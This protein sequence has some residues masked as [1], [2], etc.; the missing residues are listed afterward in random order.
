MNY[1]RNLLGE[2]QIILHNPLCKI[3]QVVNYLLS[4]Q[5]PLPT[6]PLAD[7]LLPPA[8]QCSAYPQAMPGLWA[9]PAIAWALAGLW[10]DI[11]AQASAPTPAPLEDWG[12]DIW[13]PQR[14]EDASQAAALEMPLL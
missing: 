5:V 1:L 11:H 3:S 2:C 14:P 9:D 10:P 12:G 4:P 7:G 13:S 8:P 6:S